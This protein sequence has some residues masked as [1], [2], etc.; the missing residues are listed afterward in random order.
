MG[1]ERRIARPADGIRR[2]PQV[3]AC[4]LS[5][6]T[7]YWV[8]GTCHWTLGT[9]GIGRRA[10]GIGGLKERGRRRL[11]TG[12]WTLGIGGQRE[13][14]IEGLGLGNL[15]EGGRGRLVME[16]LGKATGYWA[17]GCSEGWGRCRPRW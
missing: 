5:G 8:L 4:L 14:D 9:A 7:G 2:R 3:G 1:S 17:K 16:A 13:S 11:G 6:F 15:G 10:K 12:H